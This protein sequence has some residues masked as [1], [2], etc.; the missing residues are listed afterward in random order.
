[1]RC[2]RSQDD[3]DA[4]I[5]AARRRLSIRG[6]RLEQIHATLNEAKAAHKRAFE[7][8]TNAENR[9]AE[10]ESRASRYQEGLKVIGGV[11]S[12]WDLGVPPIDIDQARLLIDRR[13]EEVI[14]GEQALY[15]LDISSALDRVSAL[16]AR[17][18]QL[19]LE[20]E[21]QAEKLAAAERALDVTRQIENATKTVANEIFTEQFDTVLPLFKELYRRLRP[22]TTWREIDTD[23][24]GRIRASMNF[25]VGD[26]RNP[27][28]LFSSGQRRA[29][30]IAFLLAIHLSRP[31][32]RLR[33]LLLDDPVQHV[34]DYRA[35]NLVEVL[36]AV[37]CSGRQV[38]IAVEDSALADLLCRRLRSTTV[39]PGRR[40]ELSL[41]PDG[42]SAIVDQMNILPLPKQALRIAS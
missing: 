2:S 30:G 40:F 12:R 20:V 37:R 14:R 41:S 19:R 36:S 8:V 7:A 15:L 10:L 38:V 28:F 35:L 29:A 39:E 17:V 4:A 34:D 27:Q 13:A 1:M 23:F 42:S 5:V 16:Q 24:G 31:W 26:G 11:Y 3:F 22:H 6:E 33:T 32:C 9:V 18:N 25:T 21:K